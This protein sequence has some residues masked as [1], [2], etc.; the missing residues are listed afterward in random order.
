MTE[1]VQQT[2]EELRPPH[3]GTPQQTVPGTAASRQSPLATELPSE[4][5][6]L[7]PLSTAVSKRRPRKGHRFG[8]CPPKGRTIAWRPWPRRFSSRQEVTSAPARAPTVPRALLGPS[9]ALRPGG[10][11]TFHPTPTGGSAGHLPATRH[12]PC[13]RTTDGAGSPKRLMAT[14]HVRSGMRRHRTSNPV[15]AWAPCP[16]DPGCARESAMAAP[17]SLRAHWRH[18]VFSRGEGQQLC[19]RTRGLESS[20]RAQ[21]PEPH[22]RKS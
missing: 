9:P 15:P 12:G 22:I 20:S 2:P 17:T 8:R 1:Q 18:L 4:T 16:P 19:S 11:S 21:L 13:S 5:P 7:Q 3:T 10:P 14:G 6:L